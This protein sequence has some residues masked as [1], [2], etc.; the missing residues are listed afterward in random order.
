METSIRQYTSLGSLMARSK[1]YWN[2]NEPESAHVQIR[3]AEL[4]G[5]RHGDFMICQGLLSSNEESSIGVDDTSRKQ[6]SDAHNMLNLRGQIPFHQGS[7]ATRHPSQLQQHI[8]AS[9][10][11]TPPVQRFSTQSGCATSTRASTRA[12]KELHKRTGRV[13]RPEHYL[14]GVGPP[15]VQEDRDLPKPFPHLRNNS[16]IKVNHSLEECH[17]PLEDWPPIAAERATDAAANI[18]HPP[19]LYVGYTE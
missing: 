13:L 10:S 6:C 4:Q 18:P 9:S 17:L 2:A 3:A 5:N 12:E 8:S 19:G 16:W 1:P 11:V 7:V 15:L 14:V